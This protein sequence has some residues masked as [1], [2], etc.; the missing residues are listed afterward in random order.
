MSAVDRMSEKGTIVGERFSATRV[1]EAS[2]WVGRVSAGPLCPTS[3]AVTVATDNDDDETRTEV[4]ARLSV[5]DARRVAARI[6]AI[7]DH[8]EPPTT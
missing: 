8:I 2:V 1:A 6:L 5:A 7:C 3:V 4:V